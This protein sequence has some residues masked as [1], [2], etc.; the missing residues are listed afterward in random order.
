MIPVTLSEVAPVERPRQLIAHDA[1]GSATMLVQDKP[2]ERGM[3]TCAARVATDMRGP[4]DR[5]NVAAALGLARNERIA[6]AQ[7]AGYPRTA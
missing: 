2:H 1:V 3:P 5:R 7:A 6:L 4:I